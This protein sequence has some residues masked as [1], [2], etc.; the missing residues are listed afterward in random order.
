MSLKTLAANSLI[1]SSLLHET[2]IINDMPPI[3]APIAAPTPVAKAS[4]HKGA[5]PTTAPVAV[6]T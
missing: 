3:T 1:T 6:D 5:D 4:D 2:Y